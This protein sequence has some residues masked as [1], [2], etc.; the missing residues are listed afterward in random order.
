MGRPSVCLVDSFILESS[1][2]STLRVHSLIS[3]S[4]LHDASISDKSLFHS[5]RCMEYILNCQDSIKGG[6]VT[7]C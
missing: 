3:S 5:C 6:R 2:L 7:A 1:T 4:R